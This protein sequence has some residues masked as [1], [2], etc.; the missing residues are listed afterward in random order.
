MKFPAILAC[1]AAFVISVSSPGQ[2]NAERVNPSPSAGHAGSGQTRQAVTPERSDLVTA[3]SVSGTKSRWSEAGQ[4]DEFDTDLNSLLT[5]YDNPA[6]SGYSW[7]AENF[8]ISGTGWTEIRAGGVWNV[9]DATIR[10]AATVARPIRGISLNITNFVRNDYNKLASIS[11]YATPAG[12][13][14]E[15]V[16]S[17]TAPDVSGYTNEV[18]LPFE[19][20][21]DEAEYRIVFSFDQSVAKMGDKKRVVGWMGLAS[22]DFLREPS[23]VPVFSVNTGIGTGIVSVVSEKGEL[24]VKATEYDQDYR[25]I[26][27]WP[28]KAASR[29][30]SDD[31][32]WTVFPENQ[33]ASI[34]LPSAG[35][36]ILVTAKSRRADG[37]F[38]KEVSRIYT[39]DGIETSAACIEAD[40]EDSQTRVYRL[41]GSPADSAR[42]GEVL[43]RV[44]GGKA[45]KFIK[46]R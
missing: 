25:L 9:G 22:V 6:G 4:K 20:T 23:D 35:H 17:V 45:R 26:G 39:S 12:A 46:T 30:D 40:P 15:L 36:V 44:T 3:F 34:N 13:D 31:E 42:P 19:E 18:F 28:V 14:E 41:D 8:G 10:S 16:S 1:A 29:A 43:V 33:T 11:V 32:G 2:S 5:S 27:D 21:F 24:Y 7:N 37:T 38:T